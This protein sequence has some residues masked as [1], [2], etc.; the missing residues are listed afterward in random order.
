MLL[1]NMVKMQNPSR[2]P[3]IAGRYDELYQKRYNSFWD[4]SFHFYYFLLFGLFLEI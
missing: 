2:I 1:I 4:W 3:M